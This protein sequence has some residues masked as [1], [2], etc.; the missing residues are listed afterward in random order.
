M[1]E[2]KNKLKKQ[3][4]FYRKGKQLSLTG[5]VRKHNMSISLDTQYGSMEIKNKYIKEIR[6]VALE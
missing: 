2:F 3:V 6:N 1:D 5:I 4:L